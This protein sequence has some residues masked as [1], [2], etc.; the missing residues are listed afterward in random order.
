MSSF[1][2]SNLTLNRIVCGL[3]AHEPDRLYFEKDLN[4]RG[5]S[6]A[7]PFTQQCLGE[8]LQSINVQASRWTE[9]EPYDLQYVYVSR[10]EFYR[11]LH[12]WLYQCHE[13]DIPKGP[14]YQMMAGI[15]NRLAH[16]IIERIPEYRDYPGWE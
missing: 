6:V 12:C 16:F 2:V 5:F 8:T 13:D 7:T 10:I 11:A 15:G 3:N 1:L 4:E 9:V 14:V